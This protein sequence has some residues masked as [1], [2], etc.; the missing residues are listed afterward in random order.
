M[1]VSK[2]DEILDIT[3]PDFAEKFRRAIGAKPGEAVEFATPQFKRTDGRVVTYTPN[4]PEEYAALPLL[5]AFAL[6]EI[7]CG[8]WNKGDGKTHWLYPAEWYNHIPAG[9]PLVCIDGDTETFEPGKTDDDRRF[10]ML[11]YGFMQD[12]RP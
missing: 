11:A 1:D 10:G 7:G 8:V 6:R 2:F 9:T 3:D 4:T 5:P 12:D